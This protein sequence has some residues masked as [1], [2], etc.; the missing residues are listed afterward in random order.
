MTER[1]A[2]TQ[3]FYSRWARLYDVVATAPGVRSW[4]AR[5]AETLALSPGD[6]VVEMGCGTG[7]NFPF[8]RERVGDAGQVVGIDVAAGMLERARERIAAEGWGNVHALRGDAT[9]APVDSADAVLSTFLVGLL[10]DPA[11]AVRQWVALLPV[12]GRL[13]L[14]NAGR[15]DR[16]VAAPLNLAFRLFVRVT[17]PGVRNQRRSPAKRLEAQWEQ[18]RE[19]LLAGTS[20]HVEDDL[21]VGFVMLASG[22]VVD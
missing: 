20:D 4:R 10:D 19:A 8:L 1:V 15:S 2:A 17:A 13:T 5:A 9:Q 6:T 18:A 3:S 14:L 11:S 22:R 21:G 12:D 16:L 7:A